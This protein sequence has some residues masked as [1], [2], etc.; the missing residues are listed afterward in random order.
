MDS[1]TE[2]TTG[3]EKQERIKAKGL[4]GVDRREK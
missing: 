4:A 3:Q 2:Y 1:P